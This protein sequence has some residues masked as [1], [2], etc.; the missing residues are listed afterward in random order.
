M[1][2]DMAM[3][4]SNA[5]VALKHGHVV[6]RRAWPETERLRRIEREG[7][8][9]FIGL[10]SAAIADPYVWIKTRATD[11]DLLADDWELVE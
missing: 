4:F 10:M 9:P 5:L 6:R 7:E 1:S 11:A 8:A 3:D 2:D